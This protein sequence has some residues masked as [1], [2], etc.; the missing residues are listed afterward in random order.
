[1]SVVDRLAWSPALRYKLIVEAN[2]LTNEI[3]NETGIIHKF[4]RDKYGK[5]FP[6][7]EQLVGC[8]TRHYKSLCALVLM[9]I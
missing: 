6:E 3:D 7:L 2:N 9:E 8:Y 4:L 1:M 5:R